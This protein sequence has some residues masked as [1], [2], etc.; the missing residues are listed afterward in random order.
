MRA[1]DY[2]DPP[3]IAIELKQVGQ[4]EGAYESTG[5]VYDPDGLCPTINTMG[6]GSREPKII[7]PSRIYTG[8]TPEFQRGPLKGMSRTIKATQHDA[9]VIDGRMVRKLT[10]KECWRV[11]GF[12]D[13]EFEEA[14]I[15]LNK[16]FYKGRDKSKS[17]LYKQA[18]NSIVK[19]V[20]MA[21]FGEMIG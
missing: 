7:E 19:Q 14:R 13:Q 20:L 3:K 8:V 16:T 2:K 17:C 15:A 1:T 18:G 5:R 11:M 21:I 6:G 12:T 4:I 9:G 10:P